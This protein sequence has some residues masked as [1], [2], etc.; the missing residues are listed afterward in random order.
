[1]DVVILFCNDGTVSYNPVCPCLFILDSGP[2]SSYAPT[3]RLM[4]DAFS[5]SAGVVDVP[6]PE[7]RLI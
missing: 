5:V 4:G 7:N 6:R 1:M 3:K 2:Q